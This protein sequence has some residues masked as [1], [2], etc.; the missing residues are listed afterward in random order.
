MRTV[1]H[2]VFMFGLNDEIV[3][4]GCAAMSQYLLCLGCDKR[5][6]DD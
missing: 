6:G 5:T 3:H 1:F 2:N 4:T